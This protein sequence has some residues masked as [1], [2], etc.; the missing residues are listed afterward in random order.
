MCLISFI[1]CVSPTLITR[2]LLRTFSTLISFPMLIP[3]VNIEVEI[4]G[5]VGKIWFSVCNLAEKDFAEF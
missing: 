5:F 4:F 1:K 2:K 3:Y